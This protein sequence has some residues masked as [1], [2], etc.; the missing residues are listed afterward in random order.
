MRVCRQDNTNVEKAFFAMALD[1]MSRI[2]QKK[3]KAS[4]TAAPGQI[5]SGQPLE[6]KKPC[7][8]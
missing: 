6:D 1:I 8:G 5:I 2:E 7:C 4:G 3:M